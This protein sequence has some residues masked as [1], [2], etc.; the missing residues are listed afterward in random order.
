MFFIH[1]IF[2]ELKWHSKTKHQKT[3]KAT[4]TNAE[5]TD[6]IHVVFVK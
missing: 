6:H 1:A 2:V 3:N 4:T 5:I